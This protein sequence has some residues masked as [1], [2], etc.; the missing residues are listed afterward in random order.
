[1]YYGY[2]YYQ[3]SAG[4]WVNRDPIEEQGGVN[5]YAQCRND[6]IDNVDVDGGRPWSVNSESSRLGTFALPSGTKPTP[7][8]PS[9]TTYTIAYKAHP[10]AKGGQPW[11][12]GEIRFDLS[13]TK[14][15]PGGAANKGFIMQHMKV[16]WHIFK[17]D[18]KGKFSEVEPMWDKVG[19]P[20]TGK[21]PADFWEIW[22]WDGTSFDK[23]SNSGVDNLVWH[24][25]QEFNFG[26][27]CTYGNVTFTGQAAFYLGDPPN[28]FKTPN[29]ETLA[30]SLRSSTKLDPPLTP[31]SVL[32]TES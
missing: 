29:Q 1:V 6:S 11:T 15:A 12:C 32:T 20:Y 18:D 10:I 2:R 21:K 14:V 5:L 19:Q 25:Y 22:V 31:V 17:K 30:G 7:P 28:Y 23:Q 27:C 13:W 24:N 26:G 16:E 4:R 9:P 3:P 8:V